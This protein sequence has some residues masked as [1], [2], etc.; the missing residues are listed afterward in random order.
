MSFETKFDNNP[1]Y[2]L[3]S[4]EDIINQKGFDVKVVNFDSKRKYYRYKDEVPEEDRFQG[5]RKIY[6]KKPQN[7]GLSKIV[8]P[9][10]EITDIQKLD[11][12]I[13]SYF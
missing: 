11:D 4:K 9:N 7:I 1:K 3:L 5:I 2:V 13:E 8:N 10:E 12:D 6:L